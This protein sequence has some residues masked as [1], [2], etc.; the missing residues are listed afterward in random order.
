MPPTKVQKPTAEAKQRAARERAKIKD[1]MKTNSEK[2]ENNA[3]IHEVCVQAVREGLTWTTPSDS[4]TGHFSIGQT[5]EHKLTELGCK[6]TKWATYKQKISAELKNGQEPTQP[7]PAGGHRDNTGRSRVATD[8]TKGKHLTEEDSKERQKE[9][10]RARESEQHLDYTKAELE[11]RTWIFAPF[12]ILLVPIIITYTGLQS[13]AAVASKIFDRKPVKHETDS[14]L[15]T[16]IVTEKGNALSGQSRTILFPFALQLRKEKITKAVKGVYSDRIALSPTFW[17]AYPAEEALIQRLKI[18][19][20]D[21]LRQ[22]PRIQ[23]V[24][25][26]GYPLAGGHVEIE[27]IKTPTGTIMQHGHQD[28]CQ[29]TVTV[30]LPLAKEPTLS[31]WVAKADT[32]FSENAKKPIEYEQF[33]V[34]CTDE[35]I[36]AYCNHAAWIHKGPGNPASQPTRLPTITH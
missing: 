17:A 23:K 13:L 29:N 22:N 4:G 15:I 12:L 26:Q 28:T 16:D 11:Y 34:P 8:G 35:G 5:P 36:G 21:I 31:T 27:L 32:D 6:K 10:A 33:L 3:V 2:Q 19:F 18:S 20:G 1:K 25:Q 24:A 30:F 9:M 7:K 14:T